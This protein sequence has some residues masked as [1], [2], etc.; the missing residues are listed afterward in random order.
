MIADN[1]TEWEFSRHLDGRDFADDGSG[2][3]IFEFG[4]RTGHSSPRKRG[5]DCIFAL[6]MGDVNRWFN[7]PGKNHSGSAFATLLHAEGQEM[8]QIWNPARLSAFP[9]FQPHRRSAS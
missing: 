1:R 7:F 4:S 2:E 5:R 3:S 9:T 6:Q 8:A